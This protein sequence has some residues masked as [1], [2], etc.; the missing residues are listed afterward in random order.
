MTSQP[1]SQIKGNQI[2]KFGQLVEHPKRNIFFKNYAED[3]AEKL[4][5]DCFFLKKSFI[6]GKRE[7]SAA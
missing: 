5:P 3:E 6:L 4:V 2:I 7:W 1:I